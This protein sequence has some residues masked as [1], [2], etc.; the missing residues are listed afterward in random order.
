MNSI[1]QHNFQT[2]F[3]SLKNLGIEYESI[4][5]GQPYLYSTLIPLI[6]ITAAQADGIELWENR[7]E[8][9]HDKA[10]YVSSLDKFLP[11]SSAEERDIRFSRW[12]EGVY[13]SLG[14]VKP[15]ETVRKF[16]SSNQIYASLPAA[17][18]VCSTFLLL[19][20]SFFF[21]NRQ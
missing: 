4:C 5:L 2:L 6:L 15:K 17:V 13:R 10:Y 9:K 19:K 7:L 11:G 12:K 8:A 16:N 20:I 3:W 1:L 14:W 21:H 18:F